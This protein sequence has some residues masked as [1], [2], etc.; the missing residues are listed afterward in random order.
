MSVHPAA[1]WAQLPRIQ[2]PHPEELQDVCLNDDA[3]GA[4]VLLPRGTRPDCL[5][6]ATR[7]CLFVA[8]IAFAAATPVFLQRSTVVITESIAEALVITPAE[9]AWV[10]AGSG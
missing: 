4:R 5:R 7:E 2:E 8:L 9:L 10:T 6:S 1:P 3:N